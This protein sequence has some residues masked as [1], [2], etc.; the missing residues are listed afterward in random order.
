MLGLNLDIGRLLSS[1]NA[2]EVIGS[3]EV[4]GTHDEDLSSVLDDN[5][6]FAKIVS[7]YTVK[8]RVCIVEV[9][10]S[11]VRWRVGSAEVA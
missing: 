11:L 9:S 5:T 1:H 6:M 10:G 8:I 4:L 2:V 3:D 7:S